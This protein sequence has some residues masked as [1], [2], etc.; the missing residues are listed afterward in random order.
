MRWDASYELIG[1]KKVSELDT[2]K[3]Y[4]YLKNDKW[5]ELVYSSNNGRWYTGRAEFSEATSKVKDTSTYTVYQKKNGEKTRIQ[6]V[7]DAAIAFVNNLR[8]TSPNS[9]CNRFQ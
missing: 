9:L 2:S 5:Y 8:T 6:A 4:Y 3:T 7:K 1:S